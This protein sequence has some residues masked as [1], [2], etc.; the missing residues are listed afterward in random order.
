MLLIQLRREGGLLG[1]G[2]VEQALLG[3]RIILIWAR[4]LEVC[5]LLK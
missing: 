5:L 3:Q 1:R 2:E 4:L